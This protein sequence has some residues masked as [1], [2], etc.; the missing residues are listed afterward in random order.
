MRSREVYPDVA[1][2]LE[3]GPRFDEFDVSLISIADRVHVGT[4]DSQ[5]VIMTSEDDINVRI[6]LLS[7]I[8]VF[9]PTHVRQRDDNINAVRRTECIGNTTRHRHRI[10]DSAISRKV[11]TIGRPVAAERIT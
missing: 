5:I 8:E 1:E 9:L 3:V 7:K 2:T 10:E 4:V 6:A 11:L